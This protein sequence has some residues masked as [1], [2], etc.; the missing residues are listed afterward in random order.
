MEPQPALDADALA[1]ELGRM[2]LQILMLRADNARLRERLA[3]LP[4]DGPSLR[5]GDGGE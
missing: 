1:L 4:A 3:V 2:Q 5:D